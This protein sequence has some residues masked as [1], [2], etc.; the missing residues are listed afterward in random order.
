MAQPNAP[1]SPRELDVLRYLAAGH[2]QQSVAEQL[3]IA[4]KT[5]GTHVTRIR[6]KRG[7]LGTMA[8]I[9]AAAVRAGEV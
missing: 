4:K 7:H 8:G 1:L 3:G 5:V 2:T 6:E 9:V